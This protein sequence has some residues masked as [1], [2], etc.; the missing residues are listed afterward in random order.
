[1]GTTH[2]SDH[3]AYAYTVFQQVKNGLKSFSKK[4]IGKGLEIEKI[5]HFFPM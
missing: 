2:P 4:K 1:M 5:V 3:D